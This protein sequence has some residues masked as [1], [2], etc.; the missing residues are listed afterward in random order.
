MQ[1]SI[2]QTSELDKIVFRLDAEY[3][4]PSHLA[5]EKKLQKNNLVSIRNAG[6]V[7]DC[8]AFYP[9]IVPHYNFEGI[10]IPFLRV[11]EIQNGLLHLT[12]DTAFL[13]QE[14]LDDN[15][16]TIAKCKPGDL[17]I[18][19][20]GNSLGKVAL[21]TD[22]YPVYSV[23][24]DVIVLNTWKLNELNRYWLWIFLHSDVGQQVLLRTASQTGQPHL[25]V[26]AFYQLD[27]PVFSKDYQ[28]KF[29]F[30]YNKSQELKALSIIR[31]GQAQNLL[32]SELNLINW[33]PKH[34][35]T[36]EKNHSDTDKTG[37][38]DADYFQPKYDEIVSTIKDYSGG[39]A[40]LD[41]L[42]KVKEKN[43]NPLDKAEY[44]YIE[45][46]NIAGNGEIT[47]CMV[48]EG[49]NLPSRAR[50][51]VVTGDVIVSSIEGSL[52]SIALVEKEFDQALC[53]TGF[54]VINSKYYNS[55]TLLVLMKSMVSQLQLK[56]GCSG[57]ILTAINKD[58]FT[59]VVLPKVNGAVQSQIKQIITE[60]FDLRRRSKHL[61]EC[62][63]RAVKVA[64]EQDE[65]MAVKW[66]QEQTKETV[67]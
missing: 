28:D 23:C 39:W 61:L 35:L 67:L 54:Y 1:Y 32:L 52:S 15:K 6:G 46:S 62:A 26:E 56:K 19:K 18:A 64:I 16:S 47:D 65:T 44:K 29:E 12:T 55:E 50:R 21:L 34:C 33:Q 30:L 10:G 7:I 8:S 66:L 49:Q 11:N 59:K 60:S 20:G 57:T 24:R 3:Y 58:E 40:L 36:F 38:I 51:M 9:S 48:E 17:I 2:V 25:T 5:L 42:V 37:R 4:H 53:S 41:D 63:K 14:V 45:L 43:V 13:P 22:E 27:V 31:Y